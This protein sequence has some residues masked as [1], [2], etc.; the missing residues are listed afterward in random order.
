M[1]LTT[2]NVLHPRQVAE[3]TE[4]KAQLHGILNAPPH[5][6]N[7]LQDNGAAVRKQVQDADALLRQ[8]PEPFSAGEID[9]AV[10]AERQLRE[11]WLEGMPTH[12]E[13]RKNPPGAVDKN[14]AWNNK[15]KSDVLKWKNISRRLH[16]SEIG[17]NAG[18]DV[19]NVEMYRPTEGSMSMDGAQITGK[20][21]RLPPEGA[22]LPT[23]FTDEDKETLEG[24]DP[25]TASQLA[26]MDNDKR[27]KVKDFINNLTK[28]DGRTKRVWTEEQKA[29][30]SAKMTAGRVAAAERKAAEKAAEEADKAPEAPQEE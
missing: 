9:G 28:V 23:V 2:K 13:M 27:A 30:Q 16:A 25:E 24:I 11:S 4:Q 22:D 20:Q 18:N 10:N 3:I 29:E 21:Y 15:K 17:G 12:E 5:I 7:Q 8:A 6:R 1:E 19:S 14:I 26:I